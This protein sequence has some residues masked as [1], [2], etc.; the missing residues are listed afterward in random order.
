MATVTG[1]Q[2]IRSDA[3]ARWERAVAA[4]V[5]PL[6][7]SGRIRERRLQ[8]E[9]RETAL[10]RQ[11][12]VITTRLASGAGDCPPV[13]HRRVIIVH[14]HEWRRGAL[15]RAVETDDRCRVIAE[16]EDGA[17]AV[18]L[19]VVEQPDIVFLGQR[20]P[21]MDGLE[22]AA[23]IGRYAP[24]TVVA[25]EVSHPQYAGAAREAG[26]QLSFAA[27][28]APAAMAAVLRARIGLD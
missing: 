8:R 23:E 1:L 7:D 25:V 28:T 13:Y 17:A 20:L 27:T 14:Q 10:Q 5:I 6:A 3:L 12:E 19:A 26:A 22:A 11:R 16:A 21:Y 9:R 24:G 15:R 4:E 18:G 2:A